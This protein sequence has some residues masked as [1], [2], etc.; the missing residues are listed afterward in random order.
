MITIGPCFWLSAFDS[1]TLC[2]YCTIGK[3]NSASSSAAVLV[4]ERLGIVVHLAVP[5][6]TA[7]AFVAS[8]LS[9]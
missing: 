6:N 9:M 2:V 1:S 4:N 7:V 3:L 5:S 8:G